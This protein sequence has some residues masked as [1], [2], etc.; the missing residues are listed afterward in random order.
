MTLGPRA[1]GVFAVILAAAACGGPPPAAPTPPV[2][3]A[4]PAPPAAPP[5]SASAEPEPPKVE[6]KMGTPS[7]DD[8]MKP[9]Q[10]PRDIVT[11]ADAL[12]L[13]A[14]E[15]SEVGK[16]AE[17]KCNASGGNPDAVAACMATARDKIQVNAIRFKPD[18]AKNWWWTSMQKKGNSLVIL[19]RVMF[20]FGDETDRTIVIKPKGGDQGMAKWVNVPREVKI[21]AVNDYTIAIQDPQFGKL[22]YEAKLGLEGK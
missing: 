10:K 9:T 14:F 20:D 21:E 7:A 16:A 1:M 6:N 19:H 8:A 2:A 22:L 3:S 15:N 5:A 13:L 4:K 17:K 18:A 11:M 12:F